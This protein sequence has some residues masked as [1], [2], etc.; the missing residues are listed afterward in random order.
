MEELV[1]TR[2]ELYDL[3]WSTPFTTI[4][5]KYEISDNGLRKVC[6]KMQIPCPKAGHWQKLQYNKPYE[7]IKLPSNY[8]GENQITL[9]FRKEGDLNSKINYTPE[10]K[11]AI[12]IEKNFSNQLIVPNKLINPHNL[13]VDTKKAFEEKHKDYRY[14]LIVAYNS[15]LSVCVSEENIGRA[16][17]IMDTFIKVM[18]IRGHQLCINKNKAYFLVFEQECEFSLREKTTR[19]LKPSQYS[20]KEYD[21]VPTGDLLFAAKIC[22]PGFELVDGKLK[23]EHQL[24]KIISKLEI[25]AEEWRLEKIKWKRQNEIKEEKERI[26]REREKLIENELI[27]FKQLLKMAKRSNEAR[28]IRE[29][30]KD[31]ENKA[32]AS[33]Q[34]NNELITW[35]NWA[36][37]KADWYDPITSKDDELLGGINKDTLSLK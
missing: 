21:Y 17:R 26:I 7:K 36:K 29:Y 9:R 27:S 23:L 25:R 11:L 24:S 3:V 34:L 15:K 4:A 18:E 32:A 10:R 20:W 22:Y 14:H 5:K 31:F 8:T 6:A 19:I 2:I 35:L 12:E 33:N 37:N 30:L 1:L 28:F 13:I 16:L